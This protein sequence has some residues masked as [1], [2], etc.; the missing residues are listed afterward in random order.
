MS[1]RQRKERRLHRHLERDASQLEEPRSGARKRSRRRPRQALPVRLKAS[2]PS[3]KTAASMQTVANPRHL[4]IRAHDPEHGREAADE[5]RALV[6][7]ERTESG[8]SAP[9]SS[10]RLVERV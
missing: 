2:Q 7:V 5:D 6:V 9:S 1:T 3:S 10:L 4:S 8:R